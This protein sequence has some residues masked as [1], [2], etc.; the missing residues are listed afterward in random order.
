MPAENHHGVRAEEWREG[1]RQRRQ[2]GALHREQEQILRTEIA[3]IIDCECEWRP[4]QL[5]AFLQAPA[6]I[7]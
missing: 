5:G 7:A 2:R 4:H 6:V 3:R 1:R